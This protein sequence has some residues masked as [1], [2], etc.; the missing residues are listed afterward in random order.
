MDVHVVDAH[1]A[2]V[3]ICAPD[4]PG[5]IRD[6]T[7]AFAAGRIAVDSASISTSQRTQCRR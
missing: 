3:R 2:E 4:R 5:L 6:V 7:A 1:T